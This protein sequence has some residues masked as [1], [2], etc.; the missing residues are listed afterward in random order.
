MNIP[1]KCG[2]VLLQGPRYEPISH[3]LCNKYHL[4][5]AQVEVHFLEEK[6][7]HTTLLSEGYFDPV[8]LAPHPLEGWI[9]FSP[10]RVPVPPNQKFYMKLSCLLGFLTMAHERIRASQT[11]PDGVLKPS[12]PR[13]LEEALIFPF[14]VNENSKGIT[15]SKLF[16]QRHHL[17][18]AGNQRMHLKLKL[19]CVKSVF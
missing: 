13:C 10:R 4:A 8:N 17:G 2:T 9:C 18:R 1:T 3:L 14:K 11:H 15:K 6:T 12:F 5:M 7:F 19:D 16:R